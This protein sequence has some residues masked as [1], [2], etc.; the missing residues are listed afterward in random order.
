MSSIILKN[1]YKEDKIIPLLIRNNVVLY[2]MAVKPIFVL[3][4]NSIKMIT[5][6]TTSFTITAN[7]KWTIT[8]PEEVVLSAYSGYGNTTITLTGNSECQG[9]IS[10]TCEGVTKTISIKVE[11]DYIED[12][13]TFNIESTGVLKW[14]ANNSGSVKTI[15]YSKDDGL[16]WNSVTSSSASSGTSIN[17]SEGE[18]ILFKGTNSTYGTS[19]LDCSS[20]RYSTAGFNIEGNIM[21]MIYGDNFKNNTGLTGSYNFTNFFRDCTG[22]TST[23]NL[24]LPA[25][26]L[27]SYCYSNMF[28]GCTSLVNTPELSATTLANSCY[29]QM[30]RG[31][32]SLTTAPVLSATTLASSCYNQMF[33]ECINL[34]KAPELPATTLT[35][36]CYYSM[37]SGCTSLVTAPDLPATT[38][39]YMCYYRMFA[40]CSSLNYIKCLATDI[41]A[42]Y[43]TYSWVW[44]VASSGTFVKASGVSWPTGTNY[45]P[46]GWTVVE[47]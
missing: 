20:F 25:T 6:E 29:S 23:E 22:L 36:D 10:V 39:V 17:V 30:F 1:L 13:L 9:L 32:T 38:L 47:V 16:T 31:C 4:V 35:N 37:F 42:S 28:N 26:T 41:S 12:Y 45:I 11:K 14:Y 15:Q 19:S 24:I 2:K 3:S 34:T 7:D 5:G 46:S 27:A 40:G 8:A 18:T 33:Q 21:S 43:S 44:G